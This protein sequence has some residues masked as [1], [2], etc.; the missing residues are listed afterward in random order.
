VTLF[1]ANA[2]QLAQSATGSGDEVITYTTQASDLQPYFVRLRCGG[3]YGDYNLAAEIEIPNPGY[4]E[5]ENNDSFAE[6]N[7][8]GSLPIGDPNPFTGNIGFGGSYD[9]DP[10]DIFTFQASAGDIVEFTITPDDPGAFLGAN[11][12]DGTGNMIGD[13]SADANGVITC[14]AMILGSTPTPYY[15]DVS[16]GNP[17]DYTIEASLGSFDEVEPNDTEAEA[18]PLPPALFDFF[19]GYLQGTSG[20]KDTFSFGSMQGFSPSFTVHYDPATGSGIVGLLRDS[21]L[22]IIG[23]GNDLPDNNGV[24]DVTTFSP[25]GPG[26]TAPYTL[27][28][29]TGGDTPYWFSGV[30]EP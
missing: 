17:T 9:S 29:I 8:L 13:S 20:D 12:A 1:D 18:N 4:D 26:D 21:N 16:S 19:S 28:L 2:N 23:I 6:A 27:Q 30:M 24:F 7:D 5:Q 11:L 14:K 3:G 25:I 22:D 10:E 15:L